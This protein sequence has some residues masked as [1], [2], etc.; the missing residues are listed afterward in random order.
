MKRYTLYI[1]YSIVMLTLAACISDRYP[2]IPEPIDDTMPDLLFGDEDTTAY[3]IGIYPTFA[4]PTYHII[5]RSTG[6]FNDWDN[7]SV[8]WKEAPFYTYAYC[9]ES[10][11]TNYRATTLPECLLYDDTLRIVDAQGAVKFWNGKAFVDRNY[12]NIKEHV[13][14]KYKFFT[15]Y[16]DE[17]KPVITSTQ[18]T[19][20]AAMRLDGSSDLI[21][22]F[23]YHPDSVL[24]SILESLPVHDAVYEEMKSI[25]QT[26]LYSTTSG[27]RAINPLF[28]LNHMLSRIDI[29][30]QG[31][32]A[33][34]TDYSFLN[35]IIDTIIVEAP[36]QV[37]LKVANDSWT[38]VTYKGE[39]EAGT[40][41]TPYSKKEKYYLTI[42]NDSIH[43]TT[44]SNNLRNNGKIDI[45]YDDVRN[46]WKNKVLND[47]PEDTCF[48]HVA[49]IDEHSLCKPLLVPPMSGYNIVMKGRALNIAYDATVGKWTLAKGDNGEYFR[50][51]KSSAYLEFRDSSGQ[52]MNFLPG[53]RYEVTIYVY[54]SEG[55]R[56]KASVVGVDEEQWID[57]NSS[58]PIVIDNE[59][60]EGKH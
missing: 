28:H 32:E 60:D 33:E 20:T 38:E 8:H 45:N 1:I 15:F 51:I 21:H 52:P 29:R 6:V 43:N 26:L 17:L 9:S 47:H 4:N 34:K 7:D 18:S 44:Y 3:R 50:E 39:V 12:S 48:F 40:L 56:I 55:G 10:G 2:T 31:Q 30:V 25:G 14:Y 53:R 54:N 41:L 5:T 42:E 46:D 11:K 36:K 13:K 19:L 27:S 58:N 23:A 37:T 16:C 59:L 49:D 57:E 24:N 22:S 35:V